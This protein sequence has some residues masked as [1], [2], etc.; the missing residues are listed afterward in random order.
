MPGDVVYTFDDALPV[1]NYGLNEVQQFKVLNLRSYLQ[2][3]PHALVGSGGQI[4]I[5]KMGSGLTPLTTVEYR[6]V[7]HDGL[8]AKERFKEALE[9]LEKERI[10]QASVEAADIVGLL[11][12]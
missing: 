2:D 1:I 7:I 5:A 8:A 10:R 11:G 4:H 6:R 9:G 3:Y 12:D